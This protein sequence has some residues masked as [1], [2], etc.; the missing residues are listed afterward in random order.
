MLKKKIFDDTEIPIF[1]EA[2]VYQRGEYWQFRM[3]LKAEKKY[4]VKS[5]HTRNRA[6][7]ID[8][9]KTLFHEIYASVQAGKKLFSLTCKEAVENYLKYRETDL[10]NGAIVKGRMVTIAAHLNHFLE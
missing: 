6:F 1:D 8:K 9:G 4:I 2:I 7:A 10:H 3:Y 5:L